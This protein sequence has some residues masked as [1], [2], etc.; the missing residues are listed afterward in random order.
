MKCWVYIQETKYILCTLLNIYRDH[1]YSV[2]P[3]MVYLVVHDTSYWIPTLLCTVVFCSNAQTHVD[4]FQVSIVSIGLRDWILTQ[5]DNP[6]LSR[7]SYLVIIL[8]S[9]LRTLYT[10]DSAGAILYSVE[11]YIQHAQDITYLSKFASVRDSFLFL[12]R[13]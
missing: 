1:W 3:Q 10:S 7:I 11:L 8:Y 12:L 4:M 5:S 9:I 13:F 2:Q 6:I